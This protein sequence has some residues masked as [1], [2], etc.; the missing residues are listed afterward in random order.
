MKNN[1]DSGPGAEDLRRILSNAP[2]FPS[3]HP[4]YPDAVFVKP[5]TVKTPKAVKAGVPKRNNLADKF[6]QQENEAR[7]RAAEEERERE[8]EDKAYRKEMA[9]REQTAE[10]EPIAIA[11]KLTKLRWDREQGYFNKPANISLKAEI[12]QGDYKTYQVWVKVFCLVPNVK[13][14]QTS[15]HTITVDMEGNASK[16]VYL[17]YP[18]GKMNAANPKEAEYYFTA[19]LG[20][21]KEE[22]SPEIKVIAG[23]CTDRPPPTP[24]GKLGTCPYYPWRNQNFISRHMGCNLKPPD[25]YLSYGY[26]YCVIFSIK[27]SPKLSPQGKIWLEQARKRLQLAI[28]NKLKKKPEIELNSEEFTAFAFNTHVQAY[29]DSGLGELPIPDLIRI[30]FTPDFKEWLDKRSRVQAYD[31]TGK[32]VTCWTSEVVEAVKQKTQ[33]VE[34]YFKDIVK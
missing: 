8:A 9:Q 32:L 28:E 5:K 18:K 21:G 15:N 24:V 2:V 7:K 29:W 33:E 31:I 22:K 34:E 1:N 26:K 17:F 25:Y 12:P 13:A 19:Q 6:A 10:D 30:G 11:I 4:T 23:I 27:T 16:E 3:A 20:S 14:E